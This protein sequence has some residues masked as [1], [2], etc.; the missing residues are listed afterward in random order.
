MTTFK[1]M[2]AYIRLDGSVEPG[3]IFLVPC[4]VNCIHC[5]RG[6]PIGSITPKE[7]VIYLCNG[8]GKCSTISDYAKYFG[9]IRL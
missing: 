5:N 6:I 2:D 3:T 7:R 9:V 1:L 4:F 8:C